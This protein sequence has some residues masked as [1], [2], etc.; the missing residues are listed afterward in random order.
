VL[1]IGSRAGVLRGG[2]L[3]NVRVMIV[4]L[5]ASIVGI[6]CGLSALA[7]FRVNHQPFARMESGNPPLQLVFANGAPVTVT[8]GAPA[9][10]GIRFQV[11][12]PI[13]MQGPTLIS[14]NQPPRSA[15]VVDS[16][17]EITP[18][19]QPESAA[20]VIEAAI[21]PS[22]TAA[23]DNTP[24]PVL[25]PEVMPP[26]ATQSNASIAPDSTPSVATPSGTDATAAKP[27]P[28]DVRRRVAKAHRRRN[29]QG[30][31]TAQNAAQNFAASPFSQFALQGTAQ[32]APQPPGQTPQA[33][34]QRMVIV[35]HRLKTKAAQA[36]LAA[37]PSASTPTVTAA[38]R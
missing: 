9:P 35:R 18:M 1:F 13:A 12:A 26:A 31:A 32:E 34:Q 3:P 4:A 5:L 20:N 27:V 15:A 36:T 24:A 17:P 2:M 33:N 8:D 7:A 30:V 37:Q 6:G 19:V 29:P 16:A 38:R 22:P 11:I 23:D 25:L 21:D 14:S 28:E 10:F